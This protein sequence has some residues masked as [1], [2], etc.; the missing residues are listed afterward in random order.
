MIGRT[1]LALVVLQPLLALAQTAPSSIAPSA[2]RLPPDTA[3]P[4]GASGDAIRLGRRIMLDT[5]RMLPDNVGNGLSCSN[6]HL[7]GGTTTYAIPFIGLWGKFPAY[8]P[9][10]DRQITLTDRIND[11]FERSMK[12]K[13]L[14]GDSAALAAMLAYIQW[15]SRSDQLAEAVVGRGL[16]PIDSSLAP[17]S[18]RGA[19]VFLARCA[20]CHGQQGEGRKGGDG[21]YAIPPL[22]GDDSFT[23]GAGLARTYTAAAFV[24]YNMPFGGAGVLTDQDAIDVAQFFTHQPRPEFAARRRDWPRGNAPVDARRE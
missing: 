24:R 9:R 11:C 1:L 15:S 8:Q 10:S 22:W 19:A 3:L 6:C 13:A 12:G 20:T 4:V 5:K 2:L 14:A 7:G 23:T 16:G 21:Y 18:G 17:D